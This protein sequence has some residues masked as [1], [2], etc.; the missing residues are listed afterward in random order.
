MLRCAEN[1]KESC[2]LFLRI[3]SGIF[4]SSVA[5]A[6]EPQ[7]TGIALPA[8]K[9]LGRRII[10]TVSERKID[11]D[12]DSFA[13]DVSF[14]KFDERRANEKASPFDAG[15]G[16][17]LGEVLERLDEF[18]PAIGVATVVD[19]IYADKNVVG[20]NHFRPGERVRKKDGVTRGNVCDRNSVCNFR[21]RTLLRHAHVV[22]ER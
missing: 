5:E 9:A 13:D 18:W 20:G 4:Y 10:A 14:G 22:S 21:F 12:L 16:S 15:F 19:C 7:E 3:I 6:F 2:A 1:H 8:G 11:T 17:S